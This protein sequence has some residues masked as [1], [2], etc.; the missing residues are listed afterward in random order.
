MSF[1]AAATM[2]AVKAHLTDASPELFFA[3]EIARP[4]TPVGEGPTASIHVESMSVVET[5]LV[6]AIELHLLKVRV[7]QAAHTQAL[8]TRET[9]AARIVSEVMDLLYEDFTLGG[10]V[11]NVDVAGQ[12][13]TPLGATF[14]PDEIGEAE[15]HVADITLPIIVDSATDFVA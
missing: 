2:N 1:D 4:V 5:T 9:E 6:R 12:Y 7:Y 10:R 3:V 13:G 14:G 8:E 15:Y 11:R